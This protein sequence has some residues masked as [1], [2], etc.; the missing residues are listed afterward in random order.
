[1]LAAHAVMILNSLRNNRFGLGGGTPQLHHYLS[2][3]ADIVSTGEVKANRL[4]PGCSVK[5]KL[6]TEWRYD[7][8]ER[9]CSRCNGCLIWR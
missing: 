2:Y 7:R 5:G 8:C 9:Q 6:K 1:M 4:N 3:G